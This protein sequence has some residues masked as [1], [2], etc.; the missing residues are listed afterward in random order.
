MT[1][2]RHPL[3][4]PTPRHEVLHE[5]VPPWLRE[6]LRAWLVDG[7]DSV[8]D[9]LSTYDA[10]ARLARSFDMYARLTQPLAPTLGRTT[11][12]ATVV[13]KQDPELI[14]DFVDFI[15]P[16]VVQAEHTTASAIH[17]DQL[18]SHGGSVWGVGKRGDEA[19]L[20]RRVDD[21]VMGAADKAMSESG[22]AGKLLAEAWQKVY[23]RS[24]DPKGAYSKAVLAVEEAAVLVVTPKDKKS[25]L[26]KIAQV[27]RDQGDWRYVLHEGGVESA[28]DAPLH[29]VQELW[30]RDPRHANG[31]ATY[32]DPTQRE[33]ETAVF[34]AVGLVHMFSAGLIARRP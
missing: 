15:L 13:L 21:T 32:R 2:P 8:E 20:E 12:L 3:S 17:L 10:E 7:I 14:L 25:T 18:L 11:S 4:G 23:G 9:A 33:A 30:H 22:H 31:E 5:G 16:M 29:Q 24:P 28:Q 1:D 6:P 27:M 19:G 26:G 34:L